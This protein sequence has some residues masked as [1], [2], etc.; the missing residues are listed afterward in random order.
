[1]IKTYKPYFVKFKVSIVGFCLLQ[2]PTVLR[3]SEN[4]NKCYIKK[5]TTLAMYLASIDEISI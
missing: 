1:M 3:S 2:F 4:L 5:M